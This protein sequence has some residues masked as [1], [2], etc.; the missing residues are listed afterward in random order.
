MSQ[1]I[2]FLFL[3]VPSILR[4]KTSKYEIMLFDIYFCGCLWHN[5]FFFYELYNII[6]NCMFWKTQLKFFS[7]LKDTII[8]LFCFEWHKIIFFLLWMTQN[9]WICVVNDTKNMIFVVLITKIITFFVFGNYHHL[10]IVQ[11]AYFRKLRTPLENHKKFLSR[12][13]LSYFSYLP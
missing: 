7:V 5:W 11:V 2:L 9:H 8:F 6:E 13:T 4:S 10:N 1:K 12:R 3:S